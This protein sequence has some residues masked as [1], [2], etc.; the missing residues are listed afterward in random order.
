LINSRELIE[1]FKN[2]IKER[3]ESWHE[4]E[5]DK[6]LVQKR[7]KLMLKRNQR[8]NYKIKKVEKI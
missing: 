2:F 3:R 7:R 1:L 4:G 5:E 8:E 6:K